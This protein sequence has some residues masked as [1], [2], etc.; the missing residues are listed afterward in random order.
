MQEKDMVSD[1]LSS[2][3]SSLNGYE[4]AIMEC[5]NP[6]LRQTF[7]QMRDGDETFQY[8]LY[9]VAATKG[10]YKPSPVCNQDDIQKIKTDL[11]GSLL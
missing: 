6:T 5:S 9:K 11:S 2:V 3:K 4:K 1:I 8:D 7:Q 10:Y